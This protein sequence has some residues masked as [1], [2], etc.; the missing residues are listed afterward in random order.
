MYIVCV[1]LF[2]VSCAMLKVRG[3]DFLKVVDSLISQNIV[4]FFLCRQ[5]CIIKR[6][7]SIALAYHPCA[8]FS[9]VARMSRTR[10]RFSACTIN[11]N[12]RS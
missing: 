12:E 9:G 10:L 7:E 8:K 6:E 5:E 1:T 4:S 2:I 11:T 3:I